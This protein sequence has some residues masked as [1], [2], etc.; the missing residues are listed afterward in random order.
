MTDTSYIVYG[1]HIFGAMLFFLPTTLSKI[2]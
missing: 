2:L 1:M